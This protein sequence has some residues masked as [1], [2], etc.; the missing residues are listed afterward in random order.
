MGIVILK[1]AGAPRGSPCADAKPMC[2]HRLSTSRLLPISQFVFK[3]VVQFGEFV[4]LEKFQTQPPSKPNGIFP[5]NAAY[6]RIT[7]LVAPHFVALFFAAREGALYDR[8]YRIPYPSVS[9]V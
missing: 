2:T 1:C 5:A 6:E 4:L 8:Q 9:Q 3:F 7:C